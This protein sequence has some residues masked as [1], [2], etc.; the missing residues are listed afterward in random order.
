MPRSRPVF[1][2]HHAIEQ[3]TLD[4]SPLLKALSNAG[5]FDI[6]APE[7]RLFLPSDPAFA[8]TLGITPHSGG[9][10]GDYQIGLRQRLWRLEQTPDGLG[11]LAG[12]AKA[13]ERIAGR[14]ETLRDTVRVGLIQGDLHTNAPL[15]LKP[16][17]IRPGVQNFFR[18]EVA[19]GQAH[20]VQLQSLK[21]YAA[22]DN[23]WAAVT[24]TEARV[25]STLQHIHSVPNPLTRGGAAELQRH[26]LSQAISNA[27]HGGRLTISPG[28][29]AL[30]ENTLGEE[31]ARPLRVPR[32]QSGAASIEL[33]LGN[34]SASTLVRSGGLLVTGADAVLTA[35]RSAELLEQGN[36]TAAQSEVTHALARNVG[37]WA[38]GASTAAAL[39]GSG[40]VPAALVVGDALLMSKA[41]DKG[42]D[43]LDNRAIY[44]QTDKTGV[45]WRFNGRNWQREAAI[46]LAEDG[47]RMIGEQPVVA[48]YEKSQELGALA[49]AKA[50]ELALGKVPPPQNPFNLPAQASDQVGLDN[51]NW[52]RNPERQTWERQIRTAASGTDEIGSYALQVAPPER[53]QQLN[54]EALARIESN[55]A[56]GREAI[57]A[58]YLE[59]HAA[60]RAQAYGVEV[61][62]AVEAAEAKSGAVLGSD[63]RLYQ[64]TESG[65]WAGKDGVA[66]GN[67]AVELELTDQLRQ[68]SIERSHDALAAI[69]ALPAPTAA[70]M[71]HNEL[72]HRYRAAGVDLNVNPETQQAVELASQRTM[73][74]SGIT[75]P[76]MQQLQRNESGQYGYDSPIAHFQRGSDG[77]TRV[78]A[79]TSSEDIRQALIEAQGNRPESPTLGRVPEGT[80]EADT[81]TSE[82]SNPQ[83]VLDIQARMQASVAAQA[84]QEREQQDRLAQEQ[85][86]AQVREHLQQA[87]PEREDRAQSEQT[88]QAHAVLEGQRQAEQHRQ[89]EERQVQEQQAQTS[90]Q[91][92]LQ[93]RE[94]R[95]VQQRQAQERQAEDNQQR[96]Q[97][98]RQAQEARQVEVQE[99]QARQAQDQQQQVQGLEQQQAQ[100]QE[101]SPQPDTQPDAQDT[102]LAQHTSRP[103]LQQEGAS[104]QPQNQHARA[105][106]APDAPDPLKQTP[107]PGD[108]QPHQAQDAERALEMQA[109]ENRDTAQLQVASSESPESGNQPSQGA[110]ADAVPPAL[111]PS[112]QTQQAEMERASVRQQDVA[113]EQEA[114]PGRVIAQTAPA[115]AEPLIA[116]QPPAPTTLERAAEARQASP[117]DVSPIDHGA[118][119]LPAIN[120]AQAHGQ[121]LGGN[122]ENRFPTEP[123]DAESQQAQ[124]TPAQDRSAAD[125]GGALFL[126]ETMRSLRQL[127]QEIEAADRE[128]ER[129][130]K[131]WRE[132]RE[133][134]EPYLFARD[135]AQDQESGSIDAFS[136][137]QPSRR[138]P[139]DAAEQTDAFPPLVQ[140]FAGPGGEDAPNDSSQAERKSIT[141]DLD[142]DEVLYA[143]DSKN[144]LAIEQALNR[145]ANSAAT[146]ALLKKG[147]D[148]LDA[149]AQ[150]EAQEH[151][152]T[153][154]ALG[155]DISAEINT[156][157]GPVMVMTLPEFAKGPMQ[158]G[159]QGDGGGG[160]GGDGGGG[161]GG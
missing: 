26:G 124:S 43:L 105:H 44:H 23:G 58:A 143:L 69:Q 84:R 85:H 46:D 140:R 130:H 42:A 132:Y 159:P 120:L 136:A 106:L 70:Q 145:V 150:Q 57:A 93:E 127:Q 144:E 129:F 71:E 47:R 5:H 21:G 45:E 96:E 22:V 113:R 78:V 75:G 123:A 35:S 90:Q 2:D 109:V 110:E 92:E 104:R 139:S 138:S 74:A 14:V 60:Q 68:P 155:M 149:Q 50:V 135:G 148:F 122:A 137:H 8:Q 62:A 151:V 39:G 119:V 15:G 36:A 81:S 72:L 80:A 100:R 63:A 59:N 146:Q 13:L 12:D 24:H 66:S 10:I 53:A 77:V 18:N 33:L 141:G 34:A 88:V 61:P 51:Q 37:G 154:Q 112:V 103:Q 86:A 156:S 160:G 117:S 97:Q 32:G 126:E 11:A 111:H 4:R 56:T 125:P 89:S 94:E 114:E 17:D 64:R 115:T 118:A 142:V 67:L 25:A 102:A 3:Q 147:N 95:D 48:S 1:Q 108:A 131:E 76:T 158:N 40:F 30:V 101:S 28:G 20:V 116:S 65:H 82:S 128:D 98:D 133:R 38:G 87:Q 73:E 152:A 16:D 49:N 31:A 161:G 27:Y 55:I 52:E 153:R 19:Y 7:N 91:R 83:Q 157:R 79:V 54:Q 121:S 41:F 107:G 99:A 29:V 6:H 134:G 9:P